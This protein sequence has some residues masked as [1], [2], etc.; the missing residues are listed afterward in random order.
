M[1]P[2]DAIIHLAN[3]L[4]PALAMALLL[5]SL[6]RL[7]WWRQLRTVSWGVMVRRVAL[8]GVVV[9]VAGLVLVGRDGAMA[10]YG[11]LLLASA[12][13][14]WWTAFKGRA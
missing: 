5:P 14:V 11:A 6:A 4:M 3:F 10:T 2:F 9:L 7:V 13:V 12:L 1:G 8:A